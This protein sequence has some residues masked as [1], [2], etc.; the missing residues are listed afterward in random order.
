VS[1]GGKVTAKAEIN[2]LKVVS[3]RNIDSTQELNFDD[4]V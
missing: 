2:T 1:I 3:K 4:L